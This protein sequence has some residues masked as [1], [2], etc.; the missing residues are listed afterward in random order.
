M[1]RLFLARA[2]RGL[3][4]L[5]ERAQLNGMLILLAMKEQV[6]REGAGSRGAPHGYPGNTL[7]EQRKNGK[8]HGICG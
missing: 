2:T 4:T 5:V 8:R 7:R 3:K 6:R 1:E